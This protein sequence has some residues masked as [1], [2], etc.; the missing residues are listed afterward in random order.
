MREKEEMNGNAGR[1]AEGQLPS[2]A[3]IQ[4]DVAYLSDWQ[5]AVKAPVSIFNH[6]LSLYLLPF[7]SH[8]PTPP[9]PPQLLW[10][11]LSFNLAVVGS[12]NR[13]S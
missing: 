9:P 13:M 8:L 6:Y 5:S 3:P 4:Q 12:Y 10:D 2:G 7:H 11:R 1:S